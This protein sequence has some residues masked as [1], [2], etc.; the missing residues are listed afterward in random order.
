MRA[1]SVARVAARSQRRLT[2]ATTARA[3]LAPPYHHQMRSPL[4]PPY[5]HAVAAQEPVRLRAP[6][7]F[8]IPSVQKEAKPTPAEWIST[9]L[10]T[11]EGQAWAVKS[12]D[13]ALDALNAEVSFSC[14]CLHAECFGGGAMGSRARPVASPVGTTRRR[15]PADGHLRVGERFTAGAS[16]KVCWHPVG[17]GASW[18]VFL[19]LAFSYLWR[20]GPDSGIEIASERCLGC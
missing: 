19:A 9:V 10:A 13:A 1:S 3:P 6:Y 7:T 20:A 14:L 4:A 12:W 8:T 18:V 5:A 11:P 16:R 2:T 17:G 15:W